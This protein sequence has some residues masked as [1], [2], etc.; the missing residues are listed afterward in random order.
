MRITELIDVSARD[1]FKFGFLR[2]GV[3]KDRTAREGS[4]AVR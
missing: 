4:R 3:G 2:E 1:G